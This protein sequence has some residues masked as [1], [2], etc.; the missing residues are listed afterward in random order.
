MGVRACAGVAGRSGGK[1][2]AVVLELVRAEWHLDW[3]ILVGTYFASFLLADVITTNVL[4]VDHVAQ[5][6]FDVLKWQ[7]RHTN[8]KLRGYPSNTWS[9]SLRSTTTRPCLRGR[10][11]TS[12]CSPLTHA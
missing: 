3:V 8:T 2:G 11:A 5:R 7:S 10:P 12:L 9:S 6:A 1:P 4:G